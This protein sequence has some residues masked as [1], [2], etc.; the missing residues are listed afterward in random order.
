MMF[1]TNTQTLDIFEILNEINPP[2]SG[3]KVYI[4][5]FIKRKNKFSF[6]KIIE[7]FSRCNLTFFK[8]QENF[9]IKKMKAYPF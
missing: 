2:P 9:F 8:L 7:F 6:E 1:F 4:F 5:C 3:Y